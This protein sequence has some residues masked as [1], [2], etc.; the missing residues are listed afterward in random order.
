MPASRR[1]SSRHTAVPSPPD[2]I[3]F[4]GHGHVLWGSAPPPGRCPHSKCLRGADV[5][6][7]GKP[8]RSPGAS[9]GA[10][11]AIQAGGGLHRRS[12]LGKDPL[13][14]EGGSCKRTGWMFLGR[15]LKLVAGG[16]EGTRPSRTVL[17]GVAAVSPP[18]LD[19]SRD[20]SARSADEPSHP[21]PPPTTPSVH[22]PPARRKINGAAG[23]A[24]HRCPKGWAPLIGYTQWA[25]SGQASC[26]P[27]NLS[28]PGGV[29]SPPPA[30]ELVPATRAADAKNMNQ[31]EKT[32]L[33][34]PVRVGGAW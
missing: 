32:E 22:R 30:T 4:D 21:P 10:G 16:A 13:D 23:I 17:G 18:S 8:G 9:A 14:L 19:K 25:E 3:A 33:E 28:P 12:Y 6:D 20:L 1:S 2:S 7:V 26:T 11:A 15:G 27:Q 24:W 34:G 29:G 31:T 5:L